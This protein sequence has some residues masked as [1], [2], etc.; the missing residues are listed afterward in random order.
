M[1]TEGLPPSGSAVVESVEKTQGFGEGSFGEPNGNV[2]AEIK[3][4]IKAEAPKVESPAKDIREIQGLLVSGIYPGNVA[5]AIMRAY[6][7]LEAMAQQ[8]EKAT[9]NEPAK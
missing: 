9:K 8:I 6:Q 1:T 2:K 7:L 5:P 4:E 3:A